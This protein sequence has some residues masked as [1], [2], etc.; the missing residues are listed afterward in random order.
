[1]ERLLLS[2]REYGNTGKRVKPPEKSHETGDVPITD[3]L[4]IGSVRIR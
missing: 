2:I 4:A 3:G 1:M